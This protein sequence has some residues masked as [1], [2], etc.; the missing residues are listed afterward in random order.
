MSMCIKCTCGRKKNDKTSLRILHYCCN[1]SAFESPKYGWHYSDYSQIICIKKGCHGT[2][3][4]KNTDGI[5]L[6]SAKEKKEYYK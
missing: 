1:H 6:L 5:K 4:T 2:Y 3:R